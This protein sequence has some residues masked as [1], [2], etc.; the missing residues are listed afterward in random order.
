MECKTWELRTYGPSNLLREYVF[1]LGA[2]QFEAIAFFARRVHGAR[3]AGRQESA[4]SW[5]TGPRR[6]PSVRSSG[7]LGSTLNLLSA[8]FPEL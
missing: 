2:T 5:T 1:L 7:P 4:A 3:R 6:E 8:V